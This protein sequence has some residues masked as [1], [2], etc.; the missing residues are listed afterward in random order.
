MVNA[1]QSRQQ[2]L[3]V[4]RGVAEVTPLG[5]GKGSGMDRRLSFEELR[6]SLGDAIEKVL[7][8]GDEIIV[9][10]DGK[11]VAA[12]VP[13]RKYAELSRP[14]DRFWEAIDDIRA[15]TDGV[16]P[17]EIDAAIEQAIREAREGARPASAAE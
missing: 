2:S 13:I 3:H 11:P 7:S 6:D 8:R 1:I 17:A 4:A 15:A 12:V 16:A 10:R 9:E 14:R 5:D